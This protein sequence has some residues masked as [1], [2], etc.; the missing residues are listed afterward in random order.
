MAMMR[1][2]MM[3]VLMRMVL[4]VSI[5]GCNSSSQL[6]SNRE[7]AYQASRAADIAFESRQYQQARDQ[8]TQAIDSGGLVIDV[9]V[10]AVIR[11][12]I[13][14]AALDDF[15]AAHADLD[16]MEQGAPNLDEVFA[17]RSYVLNQQ[18]KKKA[19]KAAWAKA[20][21]INRGVEQFKD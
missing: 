2:G 14:S 11:R 9:Y 10:S 16:L 20:R 5:A 12:A 18:G 13:C 7:F 21:Q 4:V 1:S 19:A 17:A 8:F 15:S 3:I 6:A